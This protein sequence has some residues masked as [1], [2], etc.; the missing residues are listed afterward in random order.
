MPS[1]EGRNAF[2]ARVAANALAIVARQ[3]E[4]GPEAAPTTAAATR[5]PIND[6]ASH[7]ATVTKES[8]V[9]ARDPSRN[10]RR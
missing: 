7:A 8:R 1:L 10:T 5:S 9:A 4:L 2:H 6:V 3:L